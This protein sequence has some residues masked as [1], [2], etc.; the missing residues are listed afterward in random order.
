M[1]H[2]VVTNDEKD[3]VIAAWLM[4]THIDGDTKSLASYF[5]ARRAEGNLRRHVNKAGNMVV[6]AFDDGDPVGVAVVHSIRQLKLE[7]E[8][9]LVE[10]YHIASRAPTALLVWLRDEAGFREIYLYHGKP[11]HPTWRLCKE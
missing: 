3:Y 4:I 7:R 1:I 2:R 10:L 8:V 9:A 6:I 11:E 5:A